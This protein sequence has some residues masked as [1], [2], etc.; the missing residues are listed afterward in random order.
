[1]HGGVR[2]VFKAGKL[3]LVKEPVKVYRAVILR[4]VEAHVPRAEEFERE[5]GQYVLAGVLLGM[6]EAAVKVELHRVF[7]SGRERPVGNMIHLAVLLERV[8]YHGFA[9]RAAIGGLAAALREYYRAVEQYDKAFIRFFA[10]ERL[11]AQL[12]DNGV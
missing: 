8:E 11:N 4:H 3:V 10:G 7:A 1:M 2:L 9:R 12:R 5:P 6:V